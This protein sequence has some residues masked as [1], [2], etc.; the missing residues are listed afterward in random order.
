MVS[1]RSWSVVVDARFVL[2]SA[3]AH[4]VELRAQVVQVFA[5]GL[6]NSDF[7]LFD[8]ILDCSE[9]PLD[10][11]HL[12][13]IAA[14]HV[15]DGLHEVL[16]LQ[17]S[18]MVVLEDLRQHVSEGKDVGPGLLDDEGAVRVGD[19]F[20]D[21]LAGQRHL[22]VDTHV[23]ESRA[24]VC[25]K[26]QHRDTLLLRLRDRADHLDEHPDEHVHQ[27]H[28]GQSHKG[29]HQRPEDQVLRGH[30]VHQGGVF[31]ED[32][33]EQEGVHRD[34]HASEVLRIVVVANHAERERV[35]VGDDEP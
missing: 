4:L 28:R 9:L 35:D 32:A 30:G 25:C 5:D 31:W 7:R 13:R 2:Q 23:R 34:A 27:R 16:E 29:D 15:Q 8:R 3:H 26:G 1:T 11:L 20:L 12:G 14:S 18:V 22:D 19:D 6:A 21:L 33:H 17:P 10:I 24:E